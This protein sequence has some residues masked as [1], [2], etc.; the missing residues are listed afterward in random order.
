[1]TQFHAWKAGAILNGH[2]RTEVANKIWKYP[3]IKQVCI[4]L[5]GHLIYT[6]V[7][8]QTDLLADVQKECP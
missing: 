6:K 4:L 8:E 7:F 2:L 3:K 1:M 5:Q